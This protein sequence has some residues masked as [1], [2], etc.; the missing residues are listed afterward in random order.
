MEARTVPRAASLTCRA[1][2]R[3]PS[4]LFKTPQTLHDF[5]R[6]GS[7]KGAV[8]RSTQKGSMRRAVGVRENPRAC[9]SG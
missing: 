2:K 3:R 1:T 4:P 8:S 7:G 9:G 6:K 5:S